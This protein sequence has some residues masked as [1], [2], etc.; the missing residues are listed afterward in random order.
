MVRMLMLVVGATA[1]AGCGKEDGGEQDACELAGQEYA[2][3]KRAI[4]DSCE[5]AAD[6]VWARHGY[7][8]CPVP[9][10][11]S[12]DL[13]GLSELRT[14]VASSCGGPECSNNIVCEF[15]PDASTVAFAH[16]PVCEG[17]RCIAPDVAWV[18]ASSVEP[19]EIAASD[20]ALTDQFFTVTLTL[21]GDY[22]PVDFDASTV[23]T[24]TGGDR[25]VATPSSAEAT[26]DGARFEIPFSWLSGQQAGEYR[27][28]VR[29]VTQYETFLENAGT[30]RIT[31]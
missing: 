17:G 18:T 30:V 5:V 23:S 16:P 6:C 2:A 12:N 31:P 29:L 13:E 4:D 21:T 19:S 14:A 22:G 27:V 24:G 8:G 7:C 9:M 15:S 11:A 3:A 1:L 26:G 20:T 28:D 25:V 10:N